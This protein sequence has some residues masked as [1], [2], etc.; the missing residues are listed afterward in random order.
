MKRPLLAV[1]AIVALVNG[2]IA[3][4]E[5][6]RASTASDSLEAR[7]VSPAPAS[8]KKGSACIWRDKSYG[9]DRISFTHRIDSY[10]AI[11]IGDVGYRHANDIASSLYNNGQYNRAKFWQHKDFT[12]PSILL[13]RQNGDKNLADATGTVKKVF[14]DRIS[15]S[16]FVQ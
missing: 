14:N 4:S 1:A 8:C 6:A 13:E 9:G 3:V 7:A 15:S 10:A 12:G 16:M 11:L 2:P 5:S